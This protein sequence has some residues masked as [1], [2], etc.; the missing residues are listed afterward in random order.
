MRTVSIK[1][2]YLDLEGVSAFVALSETTLQKLIREDAFPKPRLL[3]G[4]RVAWLV[5][6]VEDWAESRPISQIAPPS[7]TGAPKPRVK[8]SVKVSLDERQAV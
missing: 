5:R 8:G 3:S 6:E 7:N 2:A 4:R 1:P